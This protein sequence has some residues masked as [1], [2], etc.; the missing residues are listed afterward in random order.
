MVGG[1]LSFKLKKYVAPI[2]TS[3]ISAL[4]AYHCAFNVKLTTY[5]SELEF[6]EYANFNEQLKLSLMPYAMDIAGLI[7]VLIIF[8]AFAIYIQKVITP[9]NNIQRSK[10][11][12]C[13]FAVTA[14]GG[15]VFALFTSFQYTGLNLFGISMVSWPVL[16]IATIILLKITSKLTL[17]SFGIEK[18]ENVSLPKEI[19][20]AIF[21]VLGAVIVPA[22]TWL[23]VSP[24]NGS[25]IDMNF[26][27]AFTNTHKPIWLIVKLAFTFFIFPDVLYKIVHGE[28]FLYSQLIKLLKE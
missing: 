26:Y 7:L 19:Y 11:I 14:L 21:I 28:T 8:I 16:V 27:N 3:I 1:V 5:A 17:K 2:N 9:T 10:H 4:T 18:S 13:F 24:V 23:V 12:A 25:S 20:F 22:L 6:S 15:F